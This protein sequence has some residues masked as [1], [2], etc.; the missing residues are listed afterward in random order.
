MK[1]KYEICLQKVILFLG[2]QL[3]KETVWLKSVIKRKGK[4][5]KCKI[6]TAM[7]SSTRDITLDDSHLHDNQLRNRVA[8]QPARITPAQ[9]PSLEKQ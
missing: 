3:T 6:H 2:L 5:T 8:Q 9:L 4:L 1:K 7:R